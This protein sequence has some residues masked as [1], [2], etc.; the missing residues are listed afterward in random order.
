MPPLCTTS[1]RQN[2][3]DVHLVVKPDAN[4]V[5]N[6]GFGFDPGRAHGGKPA[7]SGDRN[8]TAA[9]SVIRWSGAN[10]VWQ[11]TS[12]DDALDLVARGDGEGRG[13]KV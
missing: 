4:C 3:R 6:S 8:A 5:V 9:P 12:W 10:G 1:V 2:G 11:P 13:G 7:V